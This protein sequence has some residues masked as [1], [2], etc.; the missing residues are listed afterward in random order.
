MSHLNRGYKLNCINDKIQTE[1]TRLKDITEE[2]RQSGNRRNGRRVKQVQTS[3]GEIT[4]STPRARNGSFEP[5]PVKER[6]TRA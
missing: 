2:E 4:V 1:N 6:E 3:V 5:Q